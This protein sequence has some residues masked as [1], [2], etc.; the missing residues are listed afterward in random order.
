MLRLLFCLSV[1][2]AT[3]FL[4]L[5][6]DQGFD[7]WL[8]NFRVRAQQ[9]GISADTINQT[10]TDIEYIPR[11]IELDRS[12]PEF[13]MTYD[14]YMSRV[15]S[16]ERVKHG[17][18]LLARN[19]KILNQISK[20]SG[21]PAAQIV[22]MWGIETDFG[23]VKG[24]FNVIPALATLAYE[25]RRAQYFEKELINALTMIDREHVAPSEMMGSWAGAMGQCQ[26]MPS[27]FLS[28]AVDY[29]KD[30]KKD[31][32]TNQ[33]DV[34]ASCGNYLSK[35]GWD[36]NQHWGR[37]VKLTQEIPADQ[38]GTK[39]QKTVAEWRK[40]GVRQ[41]NGKAL[42]GGSQVMSLV[43]PEGGPA[44]LVSKNYNVILTWNR[45]TLF[46][47][48]AGQLADGIAGVG[49]PNFKHA[50]IVKPQPKIDPANSL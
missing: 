22:A 40:L 34:F 48:A 2:L 47:L 35:S 15:V 9:A 26:F 3:P 16:P 33:G 25:G 37:A 32:W 10:L 44:F 6:Q 24:G 43:K 21:V 20:Q 29:N 13:T 41:A 31:I 30:G 46:A 23:R 4:A 28:Y 7:D 14:Q 18:E 39:V 11:V 45:S 36:K 27:T 1:L 42:Q 38:I 8:S 12:Q 17:R 50:E 19:R 49:K 5:A